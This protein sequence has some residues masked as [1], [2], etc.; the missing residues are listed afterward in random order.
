MPIPA[1]LQE[2]LQ[3]PV[4]AAPMFL[5]SSTRLVVESCK[6]G[7]TGTLPALNARP[8]K[9]HRDRRLGARQLSTHVPL[10]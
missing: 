8:V 7:I 9:I 2:N 6:Q 10:P 5:V 4:I 3:L 1:I